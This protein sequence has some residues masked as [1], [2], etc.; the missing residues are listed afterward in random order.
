MDPRYLVANVEEIPSPSMLVYRERLRENIDR[1]L[2]IAGGPERLRPHVKTHKMRAVIGMQREAGIT[3][4]KCATVFEA[5]M[6][7]ETGVEDVFVAYQMVGPNIGRL[8][9]LA[10]RFPGTTFRAMVDDRGAAEA[11]SAAASGA[12][13]TIDVLLDF[14]VGLH[15]T[16]IEPGQKALELYA[17]LDRLPGVT[18]GGIHGYDGHNHQVDLAVRQQAC[19]AALDA[20]RSFQSRLESRGLPV[21]RRVMGGSISFPCYA[22]AEDVEPSPG[23]S[24]FWDWGYGQ[25]F[26][27]LPFEAAAL[28]LSRII[29]IPTATRVTLDLGNKAIASDPAGQRGI[30]WNLPGARPGQHNEEHW[31]MDCPDSSDLAVGDPIYVFP[32]HVCPCAALHRQV[33]VI[34]GDGRCREQWTVDARDR[35]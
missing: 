12:G 22:P 15:R 13:V 8:V 33:Y 9:D 16:G 23:T 26:P 3:K 14:D 24:V 21:P 10:G 28:L 27:D 7:A 4:F 18:P 31:I 30:A 6:L 11:L 29:S 34:D 1:T 32:T 19:N 5:K 17:L 25:R 35:E 20:V 2:A